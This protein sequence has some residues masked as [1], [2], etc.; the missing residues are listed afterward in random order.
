MLAMPFLVFV[1]WRFLAPN[2]GGPPRVLVLAVVGTVGA[3]TVLL[4]VLWYEESAP[5]GA[6]YVPAQLENGRVLPSRVEPP[7]F[8]RAAPSV[9]RAIGEK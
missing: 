3:M 4:L 1:A 5:P 7:S 8:G 9:P 2:S 6:L